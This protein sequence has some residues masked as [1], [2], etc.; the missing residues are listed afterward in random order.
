MPRRLLLAVLLCL[1]PSAA[2]AQPWWLGVRAKAQEVCDAVVKQEYAKVVDLTYPKAIEGLGGKDKAIELIKTTMK[3]L[4]D[5]GLTITKA[6]VG[7]PSVYQDEGKNRFTIIPTTTEIKTRD[8]RM[9]LQSYL[10]GISE[11][12][13]GTWKFVD[14]G[15]LADPATRDKI[16]PKLPDKLELPKPQPPEII[17]D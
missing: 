7:I 17:K 12:K 14:G 11:D 16:L 15:G 5:M 2:N 6:T 1:V 10:V 4:K 9:I 8:G 13:G 3:H